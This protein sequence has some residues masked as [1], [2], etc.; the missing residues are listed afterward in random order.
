[1]KSRL[2][3]V[4]A[5]AVLLAC[6]SKKQDELPDAPT[7]TAADSVSESGG[8]N[9]VS[10]AQRAEGWVSLFDGRTTEGWHFFKN[11]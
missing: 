2:S 5:F 8:E 3:I 9:H 10:K 4:F 11:K 7:S 6:Q 1:M